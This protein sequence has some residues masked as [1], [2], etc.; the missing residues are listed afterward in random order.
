M[1]ICWCFYFRNYI[2]YIIWINK[3]P[4]DVNIFLSIVNGFLYNG[5]TS[6]LFDLVKEYFEDEFTPTSIGFA[7][8]MSFIGYAVFQNVSS[9]I[10]PVAGSFKNDEG[11]IGYILKNIEMEFGF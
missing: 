10:I 2:C 8:F 7:N 4:F 9:A 6:V 5:F 1:V 11:N 3:I